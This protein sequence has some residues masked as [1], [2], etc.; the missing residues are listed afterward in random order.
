MQVFGDEIVPAVLNEMSY[1]RGRFAR[2]PVGWRFIEA[3]NLSPPFYQWSGLDGALRSLS[4]GGYSPIATVYENPPWAATTGC[5]PVDRVPLARFQQFM[6]AL[7]ERYD[8]DGQSDGPG[9][10]RVRHWEIGNEPDFD[11]E[12][13]AGAEDH[14][15]CFGGAGAAAY[16]EYLRAAYLGAKSADP[17]AIVL[18]GGLAYDRFYNK[19][20]YTN[21]GPF[22]YT[23]LR[24]VLDDL[25]A[26]H[27]ADSGWPFFDWMAV[28]VYNDYRGE[29]DGPQ[30][31]YGQELRGKLEHLRQNQL[32]HGGYYDLRA[33]P[34][35][36]TE[37]G[38]A[39][40]PSDD[41]TLR[42]ETYQAAYPGQL[43]ARALAEQAPATLW[44]TVVDR[45]T[46]ACANPYDWLTY[47]LLRSKAVFDAAAPCQPNPLPD[48]HVVAPHERKPSLDAFRTANLLLGEA[49]FQRQLDPVETGSSRIEAYRFT[50][51]R[52]HYLVVAFTDTW[53]R[54][55]SRSAPPIS[56]VMTV[57]AALLPD[58][59][60]RLAIVDYRGQ[61]TIAE[62]TSVAVTVRQE[63]VCLYALPPPALRRYTR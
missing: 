60:G 7:V 19:P 55:G 23:F 44:F 6:Q 25:H 32:V 49:T 45:F 62:G 14:G 36:I 52:Q 22:D 18:F 3:V 50:T 9:S 26:G 53:E 1:G 16:G 15:S 57:N 10:P 40:G 31:P 48:Y 35:A 63:P 21:P 20:G 11:R 27:G 12:R 8:R 41:Y 4:D 28:H 2:V 30:P 54:I 39:S 38:L 46:G 5:G 13:A 17:S 34:I 56:R 43:F 33:R 47:G 29:W 58:W 24:R 61:M 37:A 42:S 59:T 51:P